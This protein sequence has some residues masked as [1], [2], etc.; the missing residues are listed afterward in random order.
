MIVCTVYIRLQM[1]AMVMSVQGRTINYV[2]LEKDGEGIEFLG[3]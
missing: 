3:I 2:H 1:C